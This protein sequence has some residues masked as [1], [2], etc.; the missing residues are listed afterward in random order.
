M[1]RSSLCSLPPVPQGACFANACELF[2]A[3]VYEVNTFSDAVFC[4][5][6]RDLVAAF[7][8]LPEMSIKSEKSESQRGSVRFGAEKFAAT[9]FWRVESSIVCQ[10]L[11]LDSKQFRSQFLHLLWRV[12]SSKFDSA[13]EC[14]ATEFCSIIWDQ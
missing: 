8:P 1:L 14:A 4:N 5:S 3:S 12:S 9:K 2:L 6:F 7:S 13:V 11:W 10:S